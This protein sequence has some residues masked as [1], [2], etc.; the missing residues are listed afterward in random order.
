MTAVLLVILLYF[1]AFLPFMI[2]LKSQPRGKA[3]SFKSDI[4]DN[5][6]LPVTS[7]SRGSALLWILS[8]SRDF[9]PFPELQVVLVMCLEDD[10]LLIFEGM[11][12]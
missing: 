3:W 8:P 10:S 12:F 4:L 6:L 2:R 11:R 1:M 9:I 7:L 5:S